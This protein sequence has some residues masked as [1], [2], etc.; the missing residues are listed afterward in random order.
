MRDGQDS[1][2]SYKK[3]FAVLPRKALL[4]ISI[5]LRS[6]CLA[7]QPKSPYRRCPVRGMLQGLFGFL[8]QLSENLP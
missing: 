1:I 6:C 2:R 8:L 7:F 3:R 4:Y 5:E